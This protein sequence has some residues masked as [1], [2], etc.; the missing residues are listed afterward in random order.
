VQEEGQVKTSNER[1]RARGTHGLSSAEKGISQ[2]TGPERERIESIEY[3]VG[4]LE[5]GNQGRTDMDL[6]SNLL[7]ARGN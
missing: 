6:G 3:Q 4:I 1:Q 5:T 7:S 2:D